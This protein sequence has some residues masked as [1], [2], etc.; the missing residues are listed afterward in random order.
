MYENKK[1]ISFWQ[2]QYFITVETIDNKLEELTN[3]LLE[4]E[5]ENINIASTIDEIQGLVV[6]IYK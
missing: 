2:T 6:D 4:N 1:D 5:I 3:K